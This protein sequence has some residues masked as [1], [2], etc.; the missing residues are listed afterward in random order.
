M[1][2]WS[3]LMISYNIIHKISPISEIPLIWIFLLQSHVIMRIR[4]GEVSDFVSSDETLGV[5]GRRVVSLFNGN[6]RYF[7]R[8]YSGSHGGPQGGHARRASR[9]MRLVAYD[10]QLKFARGQWKSHVIRWN[11]TPHNESHATSIPLLA[12]CWNCFARSWPNGVQ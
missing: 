7:W 8:V 9:C 6:R 10:V 12:A 2:K 3:K 4:E 11:E 1:L 5:V